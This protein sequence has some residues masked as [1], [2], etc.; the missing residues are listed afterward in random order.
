[1]PTLLIVGGGLFGSLAAAHARDQ[2]L[3][4]IV[5]DPGLVGAA[6]SAA[7]GLFK[8]E[9]A[10]KKFQEHYGRALPLLDRLYGIRSVSLSREDG[11]KEMMGFVPPGVILERAPRRE[12]VTAAGDGWL[13]AGGQRYQGWVYVA[14]GIWCKEFLPPLD[15]HGKAGAA[16]AFAGEREGRT[17]MIEPGCQ[18]IAFVRDAGTT[19]FNDGTAEPVY[20]DEHD[21]RSL[22]R[23]AA[24]GLTGEPLRRFWGWR[25]YV[26][27]GPVF[28]RLGTRTWLATGGRKLG[29]IVGAAFA[30]RLLEE[31]K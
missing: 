17:R 23:A 7:A 25:P 13:E 22:Q 12:R 28:L 30:R 11:T 31:L 3:E 19:H 26:R 2:G 18:A 24:M 8:E 9:W 5:F 6:S 1:M 10:G 21:R 16:F 14:A 29:T 20:R 27:G 15:V 4:A